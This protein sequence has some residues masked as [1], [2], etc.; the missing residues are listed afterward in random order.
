MPDPVRSTRHLSMVALLTG[1][2]TGCANG[3]T[4]LPATTSALKAGPAY[5]EMRSVAVMQIRPGNVAVT[6]NGQ[7]FATIHPMDGDHDVQLVEITGQNS[8]RAWPSP[9]LQTHAG[10]Y[11]DATIDSPLGIYQ[12]GQGGLWITDMGLHL[13]KTRLWG[14]DIASGKLITKLTL[15]ANIAPEGSFVQ[16]LAVDRSRGAA[17]LADIANPGLITVDLESG[18]ATRFSEH[19]ALE[20]EPGATL[21][22]D[23]KAVQFNGKPAKVGADPIT[24]SGD[25]ETVFFGAMTGHSWYSVPARL[26]REGADH[27]TIAA[28]ITRVGDKPVSDGADTAGGTHY[29]TNLNQHGLDVLGADGKLTPLVRD[30]RLDWPDGVRMAADGWLYVTVN[31][32]D[33]TPPFN[34]GKDSGQAPYRIFKVWPV[35][36]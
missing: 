25:G 29:F 30:E 5:G 36:D 2:L 4:T 6:P 23:G 33:S 3:H 32:L 31:Q 22:I 11:S 12:D 17:Y 24:L 10:R 15:P 19:P 27:A 18:E 16:D 13:G 14:F 1:L 20:A 35:D 8:Y 28:A 7:I 9:A 21:K 26:L 34:D